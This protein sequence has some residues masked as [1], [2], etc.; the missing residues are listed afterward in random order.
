MNDYEE[1]NHFVERWNIKTKI[2]TYLT[3]LNKNFQYFDI[4][5]RE[6]HDLINSHN[7]LDYTIHSILFDKEIYTSEEECLNDIKNKKELLYILQYTQT[8]MIV[9]D[10]YL[11]D[12]NNISYIMNKF[13][14][15]L[16]YDYIEFGLF[17]N[18]IYEYMHNV[19][20][21]NQQRKYVTR[22]ILFRKNI[23]N[24]IIKYI[25]TYFN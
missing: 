16:S 23:P 2:K 13:I 18:I 12:F 6:C 9:D 7:F 8:K 17:D 20:I 5:Q 19:D 22:I 10:L 24:E 14:Y 1:T 25:N 4:D 11:L 15:Y 21:R 3:D